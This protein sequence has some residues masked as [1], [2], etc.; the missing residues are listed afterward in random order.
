MACLQEPEQSQGG[1]LSL[2]QGKAR[3]AETLQL[4]PP[5]SGNLSKQEVEKVG[6]EG[7]G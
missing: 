7:G 4:S 3:L 5:G 6:G 1:F 2:V